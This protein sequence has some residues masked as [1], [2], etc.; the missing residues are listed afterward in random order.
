[1][2]KRDAIFYLYIYDYCSHKMPGPDFYTDGCNKDNTWN[3]ELNFEST[4]KNIIMRDSVRFG[5][6]DYSV[7]HNDTHVLA[8]GISHLVNDEKYAAHIVSKEEYE[9][10]Y[11]H[12]NIIS[13]KI[14][15]TSD[16]YNEELNIF[17]SRDFDNRGIH[18]IFVLCI[19]DTSININRK[20]SRVNIG[21]ADK[22]VLGDKLRNF[23]EYMNYIKLDYG[24]V[25]LIKDRHL[26]WCVIDINNSPGSGPISEMVK[27]FIINQ[28]K[29]I[30][31]D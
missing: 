30:I 22:N 27:P 12:D 13:Q 9:N 17:V 10:N 19:N 21:F 29:K 18:F 8:K 11:N 6:G 26:G 16:E 14:L 15:K 4:K 1:M 5:F 3:Y 23:I 24:R 2:Q 31:C 25:E 7:D 20:C 28:F